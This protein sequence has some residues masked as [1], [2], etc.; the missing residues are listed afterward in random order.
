MRSRVRNFIE[1]MLEEE[2]SQAL[3][4]PR[5]GRRQ[6]DDASDGSRLWRAQ[7]P[8]AAQPDRHIRQNADRRSQ[9]SADGGEREWRSALLRAYRRRTQAAD[10]LIASAYLS[11]TNTR[12]VRRAQSA[13][14]AGP[15]GKDVVNRTRRQVKGDWDSWNEH[16]FVD[17]PIVRLILDGTVVCAFGSTG[18]RPR[19]QSWWRRARLGES[20]RRSG[21]LFRFS[22]ARCT[23]I[24]TSSA[25]A[26][27]SKYGLPY[28]WFESTSL[29]HEL[30]RLLS[31]FALFDCGPQTSPQ[32]KRDLK[33]TKAN[34]SD[35]ANLSSSRAPPIGG[36]RMKMKPLRS[37][38]RQAAR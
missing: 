37:D 5:C 10:A 33:C 27:L 1:T 15:V 4:R 14:F 36:F 2:L 34:V 13:V 16:S 28:L 7:R 30:L 19:F 3:A 32:T 9:G 6:A 22:A 38:T 26:C 17:E 31:F 21:P 18:G 8:S 29:H 11:R 24:A 25:T 20:A 35:H 23:S 12:R